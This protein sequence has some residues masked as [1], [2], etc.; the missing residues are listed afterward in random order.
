MTTLD[1]DAITAALDAS[2]R[3]LGPRRLAM[4]LP[5]LDALVLEARRARRLRHNVETLA[6][7]LRRFHPDCNCTRF[8]QT[9][10]NQETEP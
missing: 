9:V 6:A 10:L 5:W 3:G 1:L 4:W 2:R 7:D 8:A